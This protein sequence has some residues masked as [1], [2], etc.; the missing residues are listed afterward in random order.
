MPRI[1]LVKTSSLGDVVHNLPAASDIAAVFPDARIDW[2]VEEL[3]APIPRM[4]RH[5][6]RVI[7]VALRRWRTAWWRPDT[8]DEAASFLR[9]LR[10]ARYDVIL[11]SQG[12]FKSAII[13]RAA[14]GL[15]C[16]LDWH[17]AREPLRLFYDRV[18]RVPRERHAVERN[19]ELAARA[20]G[21][22]GHRPVDYGIQA[23]ETS[24][25]WL[26][27]PRYAVLVHGT[28]APE[29]VWTEQRWIALGRALRDSE[30]VAVLPWG[31]A[32]ERA[33]SARLAAAI[34]GAVVTPALGISEVAALLAG[35]RC[36]AGVDTGLTH[37]A[38]ALGVATVGIYTAT[39]PDRT[40]VYGSA[41][42]VNLGAPGA[43]PEPDA[44]LEALDRLA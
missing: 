28:S 10:Q 35:A 1:L 2:V 8:R 43:P 38:A 29:K 33:R 42:A 27:V 22:N 34:P 3:F 23:P 26:G 5:V 20:F 39:S 24:F 11:D 31:S 9:E 4:H 12:L 36:V 15:R 13:A 18:F 41:R 25:A 16:G 30:T 44:V 40:G 17:S 19:R 6:E 37:L 32:N 7:P 21:Y 14:H